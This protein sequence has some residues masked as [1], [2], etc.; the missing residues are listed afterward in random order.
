[1]FIKLS[2]YFHTL[3]YLRPIQIYGRL[4]QRVYKPSVNERP[5]PRVRECSHSVTSWLERSRSM[6]D[7]QTFCFLNMKHK[8]SSANDWDNAA[9]LKLWRYNLHYFDD[10]N[11]NGAD[12]RIQWHQALIARWITENPAGK[13]TAWEPYPT[14]L[15]IV[16]W[17]KWA[18]RN[19]AE[20]R[21]GL[22]SE[23]CNS[24]A[25]Q[26][27]W[28]TKRLEVHLLGNHL[29]A[30]AKALVFA[31]IFFEGPEAEH[32]LEQGCSILNEEIVEQILEDGGHFERSPMY[33]GT[34]LED[35]LDV[36]HLIKLFPE[37]FNQL[38]TIEYL[39]G[40][41]LR[42]LEW[43][44]LMS[45]PDGKISF[46][47]DAAFEIAPIYEQLKDYAK[48]LTIQ[49]KESS[50][51][52]VR[53]L[54]DSGYIRL[55]NGHAVVISDV[56]PVGPDYLP[57]HA[58]ADTLSFEFSLGEQRVF[59]NSGTS[60][61]VT[62]AERLRQRSTSAHNTVEVDKQNS[63]DVWGAFR[64]ARRAR[65]TLL[66]AEEQDKE[67]Y[68][69]GL[70]DGYQRLPGRVTHTRQWQLSEGCLVVTDSL[71]GKWKS[72]VARFYLHPAINV[73]CMESKEGGKGTLYLNEGRE[74]HFEAE[75]GEVRIIESTWHPEFGRSVEAQCIE[76][77]M[78]DPQLVTK[79]FWE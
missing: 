78:H 41:A 36:I 20:G 28:L 22:A 18:F 33:Q 1:M 13:G 39:Q 63:S 12:A 64:V 73:K 65:P 25:I 19:N 69:L 59:V 75:R 72:A 62:G 76:I 51:Q 29:W 4:W 35:I 47:N 68:V 2:R 15:R 10:F 42:M 71:Q 66:R 24:L 30:N 17:I 7:E 61:Y 38:L 40:I 16:N 5:A 23:A 6:L 53:V 60:E 11:A 50:Q 67:L 77:R 31:G 48:R 8:V 34:L 32:W 56:G 70:H 9:H 14:S 44:R 27:R 3:R 46:F 49:V 79:F 57:G 74:I 54:A 52:G 58:H 37:A 55:E 21:Q 26:A 45:H 43:L